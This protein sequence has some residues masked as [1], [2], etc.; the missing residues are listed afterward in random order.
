MLLPVDRLNRKTE[1]TGFTEISERSD[2]DVKRRKISLEI[3]SDA[4][5]V[6][7]T[8][9]V[10]FRRATTISAL[11]VET[12]A[13]IRQMRTRGARLSTILKT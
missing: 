2:V 4:I 11:I 13:E 5:A 3:P 10:K 7:K 8:Q 12:A 9:I 6:R 1:S